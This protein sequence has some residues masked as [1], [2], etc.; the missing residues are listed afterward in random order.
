MDNM[1]ITYWSVR[2][3]KKRKGDLVKGGEGEDRY[4]SPLQGYH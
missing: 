1:N 2:S 4:S 3:P